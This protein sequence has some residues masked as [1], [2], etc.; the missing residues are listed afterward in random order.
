[1][2]RVL[3]MSF[4]LFFQQLIFFHNFFS[5]L[6]LVRGILNLTLFMINL[7]VNLNLN[8]NL[9]LLGYIVYLFAY[10]FP[11]SL[12][13]SQYSLT[14]FW[15]FQRVVVVVTS[16]LYHL[17]L[18]LFV[19]LTKS[20][21]GFAINV[22]CCKICFACSFCLFVLTFDQTIEICFLSNFACCNCLF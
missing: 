20:K 11:F 6:V 8:L 9:N 18:I 10:H 5:F 17:Q 12:N 3:L 22:F 15:I 21:V 2:E 16:F 1:M 7:N 14:W 4:V 13:F 19:K